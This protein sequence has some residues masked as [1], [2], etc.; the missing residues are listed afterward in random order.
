M[1]SLHTIILSILLVSFAF[2]Q[3]TTKVW[4]WNTTVDGSFNMTQNSY[5][6]NWEG[7]EAG[8][9]I[10]A[11]NLNALAKKQLS[12]KLH[13]RNA[14][15]LSFG[16]THSQDAATKYWAGPAKSTD[17]ID[18]ETL[19]RFTFGG[20]IDPFSAGRLESQFVD[21]SD[22]VNERNF[23]PLRFTESAGAIKMLLEED[24]REWSVRAGAA[25]RQT[26][27]R[28]EMNYTTMQKEDITTQDGGLEFVSELST[29]IAKDRILL[30]SKLLIYKALYNSE[31]ENLTGDAK[32]YWKTTDVD[33]E[34]IFSASITQYIMVNLYVQWKY[35]KEIDLAGRFKQ[36]LSLGLT[37]KFI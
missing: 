1:K 24:K 35:D 34:N 3:D 16:Q 13:N 25:F 6:D 26:M 23:N 31:S 7:G 37:Y 29:P 19:F 2:A 17:L 22:P 18:F 20:F 12:E 4:G 32:D 27:D 30:T 5:S 8:S 11:A 28:D 9:M 14:L 10:W 21:G 15:K 33:W 36:T